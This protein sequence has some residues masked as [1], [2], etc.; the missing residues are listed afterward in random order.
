MSEVPSSGCLGSDSCESAP[1]RRCKLCRSRFCALH[2]FA[3]PLSGRYV[4]MCAR[5]SENIRSVDG[6]IAV[7]AQ[8]SLFDAAVSDV[9]ASAPPGKRRRRRSGLSGEFTL[10]EVE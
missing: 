2:I 7:F 1:V 8:S 5:C 4:W 3:V 10:R 9:P 6:L